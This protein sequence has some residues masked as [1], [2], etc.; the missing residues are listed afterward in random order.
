MSYGVP[1]RVRCDDGGENNDVCL[2]MN[3]YRGSER[4][5]AIHG[6]SVHNQR[7]ERLWGIFGGVCQMSIISSSLSWKVKE[8]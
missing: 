4:G 5:S 6:R 3:V 7:I 1:S 2:F 8:S